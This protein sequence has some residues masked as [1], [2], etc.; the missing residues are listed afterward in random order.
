VFNLAPFSFFFIGKRQASNSGPTQFVK[1][2]L[3][4]WRR[5]TSLPIFFWAGGP[6]SALIGY[7]LLDIGYWI[8]AIGYCFLGLKISNSLIKKIA[9]YQVAIKMAV[10]QTTANG[11]WRSRLFLRR[12]I[13]S[14]NPRCVFGD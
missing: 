4:G 7:W 3:G 10:K 6:F 1:K 2:K 11:Q 8:L 12:R 13:L 9:G 14:E 5:L